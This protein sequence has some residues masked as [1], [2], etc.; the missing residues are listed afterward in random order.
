VVPL[1]LTPFPQCSLSL[2][3]LV[4][5]TRITCGI[6]DQ[7]WLWRF[8]R[9]R[10]RE[11]GEEYV[12]RPFAELKWFIFQF[13]RIR[14]MVPFRIHTAPTILSSILRFFCSMFF[15]KLIPDTTIITLNTINHP[16]DCGAWFLGF[17][18]ENSMDVIFRSFM[19]TDMDVKMKT[20]QL[21]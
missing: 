17:S 8:D 3:R 20:I 18:S 5:S 12:M 9:E 19:I 1:F 7:L 2:L 10:E 15:Q 6:I 11:I 21:E 16:R 13:L 14:T 4:F